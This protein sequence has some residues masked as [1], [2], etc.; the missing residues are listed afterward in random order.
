MHSQ[1]LLA[2]NIYTYLTPNPALLNACAWECISEAAARHYW[3][4]LTPNILNDGLS[5]EQS[6]IVLTCKQWTWRWNIRMT[7]KDA[8]QMNNKKSVRHKKGQMQTCTVPCRC[9]RSLLVQ[10]MLLPLWC[11]AGRPFRKT[12]MNSRKQGFVKKTL[13]HLQFTVCVCVCIVVTSGHKCV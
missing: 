6:F 13:T 11:L 1:T 8:F 7:T 4:L 3:S 10:E 9:W 12:K 5:H 2:F